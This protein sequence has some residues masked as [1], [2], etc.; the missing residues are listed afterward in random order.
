MTPK[1]MYDERKRLRLE[2]QLRTEQKRKDR[3]D[4][5]EDMEEWIISIATSLK[6]LAEVAELWA[7]QQETH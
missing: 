3:M 6:R 2:N 1:Q 5:D 7:D 4:R